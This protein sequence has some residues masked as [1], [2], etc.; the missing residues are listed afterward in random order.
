MSIRQKQE[1]EPALGSSD[2]LTAGSCPSDNR[3]VNQLTGYLAN[4]TAEWRQLLTRHQ[5][6]THDRDRLNISLEMAEVKL[7]RLIK[8]SGEQE[9]F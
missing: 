7:D 6:L 2:V 8:N 5:N 1:G 9:V 4:Q 3:D